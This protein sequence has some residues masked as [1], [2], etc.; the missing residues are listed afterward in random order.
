MGRGLDRYIWKKTTN[1][2]LEILLSQIQIKKKIIRV[3]LFLKSYE[4]LGCYTVDADE[5]PLVKLQRKEAIK[6]SL[7][8]N[9][10]K[11]TSR[12]I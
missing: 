9:C 10:L 2:S 12:I 11:V 7:L 1:Y 5:V 8:F 6:L 3:R 4:C